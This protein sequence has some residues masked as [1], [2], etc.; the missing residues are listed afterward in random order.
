MHNKAESIN[1]LLC[2]YFFSSAVACGL[3][4]D[5]A[6]AIG[7]VLWNELLKTEKN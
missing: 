2:H 4:L 7:R 1:N 5:W 6:F 3:A